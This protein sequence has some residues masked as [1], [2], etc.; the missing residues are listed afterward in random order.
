M[1][2][3]R[4]GTALLVPEPGEDALIRRLKRAVLLFDDIAVL[5]LRGFLEFLAKNGDARL[6]AELEW[7]LGRRV[8][9]SVHPRFE[10]FLVDPFQEAADH[11]PNV[12]PDALKYANWLSRF[13]LETFQRSAWRRTDGVLLCDRIPGFLDSS[14]A[15]PSSTVTTTVLSV[16]LSA[17]PEPDDQTPWER[18]L[19]FK[20][21]PDTPRHILAL[22][23]WI[24]KIAQQRLSFD[25]M[26]EEI[27][28]VVQEY[29][30]HMRLHRLKTTSGALE[31]VVTAAGELVENI[32]KLKFSALAKAMFS[33]R[34]RKIQLLDAERQ[35][36]GRELAYLIKARERFADAPR[37]G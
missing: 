25:E 10:K 12:A 34:Q 32:V 19:E 21:D 35:A 16:V 15:S 28:W 18:I 17:F 11:L 6:Q 30:A 7:L 29:Q 37:N 9:T 2:I 24:T 3:I 26:R 31:S 23:R 22:K 36:P 14:G 27:E 20:S 1:T 5:H 8:L 33:L 13:Q 4:L